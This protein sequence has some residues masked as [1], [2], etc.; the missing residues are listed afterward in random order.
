MRVKVDV[1]DRAMQ[2][3]QIR[4]CICDMPV[5]GRC[6]KRAPQTQQY[7]TTLKGN[8]EGKTGKGEGNRKRR[9]GRLK[10]NAAPRTT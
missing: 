6:S 9:W 4:S 2:V 8:V 1:Q 5:P 3:L 7:G 10:E